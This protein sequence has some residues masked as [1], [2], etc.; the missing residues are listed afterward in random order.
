M[1]QLKGAQRLV[2]DSAQLAFVCDPMEVGKR[3]RAANQL[4]NGS[5]GNGVEWC[6]L[7]RSASGRWGGPAAARL[8][9]QV[10]RLTS[11]ERTRTAHVG[12]TCSFPPP[13][14]P[15]PTHPSPPPPSLGPACVVGSGARTP[16]LA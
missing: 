1:G 7:G 4:H 16:G 14:P 10:P 6:R 5:D 11:H 2:M 12:A 15:G 9:L 3:M 13:C 8:L